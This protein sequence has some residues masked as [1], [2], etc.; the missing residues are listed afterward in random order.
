MAAASGRRYDNTRRRAAAE[1]TRR[2]VVRAAGET[3]VEQ[4]YAGTALAEVAERA[5]VSVETIKKRF[6]TKRALFAA[7]FDTAV[8]GDEGVAV[9]DSGWVDAL[10]E[11]A[12]LEDRLGIVASAVTATHRRAASALTVAAAAA[13]ADPQ[14]ADWW[15]DQRKR[16]RQD[17]ETILPLAVGDT[18][19]TLPHDQ[20]VDA[21]YAVSETHVFLVL[22]HELGWP[23]ERYRRWLAAEFRHLITTASLEDA[24]QQGGTP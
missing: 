5:G 19:P 2:E 22:T 24:E 23:D 6:G 17:V 20:L 13:H 12:T 8:A 10:R 14:I 18:T 3:F 1:A 7:W 9:V 11:A 15:A 21:I 4:G 16:R